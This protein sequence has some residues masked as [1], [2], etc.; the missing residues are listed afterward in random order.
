MSSLVA[1][2]SLS[3]INSRLLGIDQEEIRRVQQYL[4]CRENH[5]A[6]SVPLGDAWLRFYAACDRFLRALVRSHPR[7]GPD[8]DD[9]V[10]EIWQAILTRLNRFLCEPDRGDFGAWI[11]VV[12]H[13]ILIDRA[14]RLRR[15]YAESLEPEQGELLPGREPDPLHVLEQQLRG[16]LIRSLLEHLRQHARGRD[17]E[18]IRLRWLEGLSMTEIAVRLNLTPEQ[19]RSRH[20]RAIARLRELAF[21]HRPILN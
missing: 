16:E 17:L 3:Q 2:K 19:V 4:E 18:L 8:H 21:K 15:R 9:A 11:A 1:L 10:Q 20:H 7:G 6:P 13:R 14:R 12:S 5:Q